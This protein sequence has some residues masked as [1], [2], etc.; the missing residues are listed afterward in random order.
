MI[1]A[2]LTTIPS[3]IDLLKPIL[4]SVLNQTIPIDHIEINIPYTCLRTEEEYTIPEWMETMDKLL[5]FR[6]TDYGAITKIA[7]TLL[8]HRGEPIGIWSI[9][10][11]IIYP[12]CLLQN[13][14]KVFDPSK[15]TII[16]NLGTQIINRRKSYYSTDQQVMMLE[17]SNSVLYP[18]SC[19]V[20]DFES[21]VETTSLD[22]DSRKS[23]DVILSNYFALHKI[24]IIQKSLLNNGRL[25][26]ITNRT[27]QSNH[28]DALWLQDTGHS[29]RY[30]RVLDYLKAAGLLAPSWNND[31]VFKKRFGFPFNLK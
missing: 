24:P 17:G 19:I 29:I 27:P 20:D 28:K 22:S 15:S 8:R 3:R 11:D 25:N 6:T 10:D 4:D 23:D 31:S 26:L 12:P 9:D 7:P 2:S 18:T 14:H 1:I 13:L 21:Y 30:I 5:I 16:C